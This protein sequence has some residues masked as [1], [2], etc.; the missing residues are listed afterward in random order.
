MAR[1]LATPADG[2]Q[3]RKNGCNVWDGARTTGIWR[4]T[5]CSDRLP[6]PAAAENE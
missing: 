3:E 6:G 4:N 2:G 1:D 5:S